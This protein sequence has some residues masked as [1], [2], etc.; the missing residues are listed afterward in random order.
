M[1][2]DRNEPRAH[3]S[4]HF[5]W[6]KRPSAEPIAGSK[7]GSRKER[8]LKWDGKPSTGVDTI[9][10]R[11]ASEVES[12]QRISGPPVSSAPSWPIS[13]ESSGWRKPPIGGESRKKGMMPTRKSGPL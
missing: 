5:S 3:K 13:M 9:T 4:T 7:A 1:I 2:S 12:D 6:E 11:D 8:R 10:S